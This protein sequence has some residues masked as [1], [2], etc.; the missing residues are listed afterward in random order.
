MDH[1]PSAARPVTPAP[2]VV[3]RRLGDGAVLVH[4]P[5]NKIF[6]LNETG[7]RVWELIA[8]GKTIAA[9]TS[10]LVEE[11]DVDPADAEAKIRIVVDDL[12]AAGL[13]R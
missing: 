2:D 9:M 6:E 12:S 5:T 13:V 4:L 7:A 11:Y 10:A 1:A 8:S 3:A